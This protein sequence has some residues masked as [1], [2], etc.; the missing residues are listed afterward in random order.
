[1]PIKKQRHGLMLQ[2]REKTLPGA[3]SGGRRAVLGLRLL[4]PMGTISARSRRH[5]WA[6]YMQAFAPES[7]LR[8]AN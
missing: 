7:H 2:I 4:A 3:N 8:A 1:M 5:H 6:M